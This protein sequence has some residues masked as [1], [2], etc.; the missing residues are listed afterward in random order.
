MIS[1]TA[2]AE[3]ALV[4]GGV[5]AAELLFDR[6]LPRCDVEAINDVLLACEAWVKNDDSL[7]CPSVI[8]AFFD[9]FSLAGSFFI[10]FVTVGSSCGVCFL[11]PSA[12]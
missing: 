10:D 3:E 4:S 5:G 8:F 6:D 1:I 9:G 2:D 12:F 11:F 7:V